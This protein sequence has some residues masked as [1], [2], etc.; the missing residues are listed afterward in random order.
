MLFLTV[1]REFNNRKKKKKGSFRNCKQILRPLLVYDFS[2][3][4]I[5]TETY[6]NFKIKYLE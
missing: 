5:D 1:K 3:I 2:I 4:I 6:L